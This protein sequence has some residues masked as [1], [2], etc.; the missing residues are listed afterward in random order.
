MNRP[1]F[2]IIQMG[3]NQKVRQVTN[4]KK[5]VL[6]AKAWDTVRFWSSI[7]QV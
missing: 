7:Q 4:N 3:F 1:Y 5:L 2:I 6:R